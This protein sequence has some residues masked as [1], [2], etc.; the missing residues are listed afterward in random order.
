MHTGIEDIC[1]GRGDY[2][3]GDKNAQSLWFWWFPS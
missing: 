2:S 1:H 3:I